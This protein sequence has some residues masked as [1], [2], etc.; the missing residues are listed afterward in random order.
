MK[1]SFFVLDDAPFMQ[2]LIKSTLVGSGYR[3]VGTSGLPSEAIAKIKSELPDFVILDLVLP[4]MNG[5]KVA[6]I[7]RQ[8]F[9]GIVLIGCTT[10]DIQNIRTKNCDMYIQ[11][12]F[13]ENDLISAV[14]NII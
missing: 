3:C 10:L 13:H 4:E 12:P 6:E 11:K 14:A 8:D 1:K 9:A 2:E 7:I 5:E